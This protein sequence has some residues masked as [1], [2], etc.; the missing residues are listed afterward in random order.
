MEHQ[1]ELVELTTVFLAALACGLLMQK[2]R[3]PP[4]VGYIIAGV[5]LGPSVL[6]LLSNLEA[7]QFLA[8]LGAILLM[9]V[10]GM[11]LSLRGFRRVYRLT[12][13]IVALQIAFGLAITF[14]MGLVF[15]WSAGLSLVLGFAF[16]ISSTAVGINLLE[17]VGELRGSVGGLAVGVLIAQ[18]LAIIPMLVIIESL[19]NGGRIDPWTV[20]KLAAAVGFLTWFVVFMSQRKRVSLPFDGVIAEGRGVT[21]LAALTLCFLFSTISGLLGVSVAFGAFVAGLL[22]GN[23]QQRPQFITATLPVRDILL[24]V[25]FLSI[26]LLIDVGFLID[27]ALVLIPLVILVFI[28]KTVGNL[29]IIHGLGQ[30]WVRSIRVATVLPQI[31]EFSFIL[32]ATGLSA[33]ILS[34]SDYRLL[35]TVIALSL[36]ASP[37]WLFSSRHLSSARWLVVITE[38]ALRAPRHIGAGANWLSARAKGAAAKRS[39]KTAAGTAGNPGRGRKRQRTNRRRRGGGQTGRN[40]RQDRAGPGAGTLKRGAPIVRPAREA[41]PFA[42]GTNAPGRSGVTPGGPDHA[43]FRHQP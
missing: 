34:F 13:G 15:D 32:G 24:M 18:D 19:G 3:Q 9:F 8:E 6:G 14:G 7:I 33:G 40:R 26:G 1:L 38:F 39:R 28:L 16:A 11:E 20:L 27:N 10:V 35:V 21:A 17:E 22:I 25:F 23:S 5:L 2:L 12:L 42:P 37:V 29:A 36:I 31:G 30:P 43:D 4:L 41:G